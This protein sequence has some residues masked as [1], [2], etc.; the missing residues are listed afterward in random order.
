MVAYSCVAHAGALGLA[1]VTPSEGAM[2]PP[3]V[4]DVELLGLPAAPP[5]A[6]APPAPP[7]AAPEPVAAEPAP[8]PP[9]PETVV[10][11]EKSQQLPKPD[12]KP[13]P[14]P[15][16]RPREPEVFREPEKKVEKSLDEILAEARQQEQAQKGREQVLADLRGQEPPS[17]APPAEAP[18]GGAG[19]LL[20]AE[21]R[22][23]HRSVR[24]HMRGIWALPAGFRTQVLQTTVSVRLDASGNILGNPEIVRGSGNPWYDDSVEG[25]LTKASPLPKPPSAGE[26]QLVFRPEDSF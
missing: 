9:E 5:P 12:P 10:L 23:W 4:I 16:P 14:K 15:E 11:P 13:E 22:A 17:E 20:S 7:E 19:S 21:E 26:Y 25:A 6:P 8:P 2:A 1:L 24:Q 3:Q 18:R